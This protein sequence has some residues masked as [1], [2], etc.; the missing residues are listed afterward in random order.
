MNCE[1]CGSGRFVDAHHY[2]CKEGQLSPETVNLCRR[3]H[4]TYHSYGVE[5]FE[6]E[7]LGKAIELENR[8]R[9]IAYANRKNLTKPLVLFK[10]EDIRRSEYWNK[11][12]GVRKAREPAQKTKEAKQLGFEMFK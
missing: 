11:I 7:Y 6:D 1:I 8:R 9:E 4:R 12:H 3:C 5:W 2:D 10:R